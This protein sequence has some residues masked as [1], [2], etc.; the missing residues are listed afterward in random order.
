MRYQDDESFLGF[1]ETAECSRWGG[2]LLVKFRPI[3]QAVC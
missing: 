2:V 3:S 1:I